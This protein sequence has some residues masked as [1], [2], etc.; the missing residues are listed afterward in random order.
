MGIFAG[1]DD[2]LTVENPSIVNADDIDA[3]AEASALSFSV[4]QEFATVYKNL[5]MFGGWFTGE[6]LNT[7]ISAER[8]T[9]IGRRTINSL[10]ASVLTL[11]SGLARTVSLGTLVTATVK[12]TVQENSIAAA[13]AEVF[14]GYAFLYMGE[15]FCQGVVNEG[16]AISREA[17]MD[18]TIAHL[19]R[20]ITIAGQV[21]AAANEVA[22][23]GRVGLAE[24]YL[25]KGSAALAQSTAESVTA[26]FTFNLRYS[27]DLANR[28]RLGNTIW[29]STEVSAAPAYRALTDPRVV[30]RAPNVDRI[31][32]FDGVTPMWTLD[33][34]KSY[35][36]PIRLASRLEADYVAAEA[37]GTAAMLTMLQQRRAA[38]GQPAY[39]GGTDATSVLREFLEQRT[40]DFYVEGKRQADFRRHPTD[41]LTLAPTGTPYFKPFVGNYGSQTCWPLPRAETDRN[42]NF[43]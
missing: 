29:G 28:G 20:G 2:F 3:L 1:C 33:K 14:N 40:R 5:A 37:K 21:G 34:Y 31:N 32:P 22:N 11:F 41:L 13:R 17:M 30:T 26:G 27:D 7:D 19:T 25:S 36:A 39:T 24:A 12:G 23:I 9:N 16:P 18:S 42:P 10:D 4:Q 35:S 15:Y 43:R 8:N 38:N 6:L